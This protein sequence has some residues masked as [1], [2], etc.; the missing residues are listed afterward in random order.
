MNLAKLNKK[1][2]IFWWWMAAI[3]LILVVVLCFMDGFDKWAFYFL[4]PAVAAL[5]AVVR[6]FLAKK[7]EK[8][9]AIRDQNAKK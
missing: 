7:L 6:R 9:E 5:L 1:L 4:A 2:E 3:S 8:S